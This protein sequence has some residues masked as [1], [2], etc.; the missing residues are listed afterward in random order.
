VYSRQRHLKLVYGRHRMFRYSPS[1]L[2]FLWLHASIPHSSP[3]LLLLFLSLLL[4]LMLFLIIR[5]GATP[6]RARSSDLAGRSTALAPALAPPCLLLCFA[7]VIVRTENK[8][9][10]PLYLF[11]ILTLK[12]S[13]RRW[14]RR[15]KRSSTFFEEKKYLRVTWLED[16]LTP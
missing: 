11:Y 16:V 10:W 12:Q 1:H 14:G 9:V 6:E 7:S 2:P 3:F 13:Q 8:N 5:G 15:L 4:T